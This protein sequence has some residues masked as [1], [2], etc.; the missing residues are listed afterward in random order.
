ME[1]TKE[2]YSSNP[3]SESLKNGL[4]IS[5]SKLASLFLNQNQ[6]EKARPLL[7]EARRIWYELAELT[8]REYY[9]SNISWADEKLKE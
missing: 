1:L 7:Y 5:Y 2:L 9:Q 4:A 6:N 3:Q 8:G